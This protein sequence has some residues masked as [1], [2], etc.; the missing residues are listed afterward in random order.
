MAGALKESYDS[1]HSDRHT[2]DV[3]DAYAT[4]LGGGAGLG[5]IYSYAF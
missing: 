2:A 4:S 3:H 1:R 5:C